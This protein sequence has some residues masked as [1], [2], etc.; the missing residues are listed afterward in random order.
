[1]PCEVREIFLER[2]DRREA[3]GAFSS[4]AAFMTGMF[5]DGGFRYCPAI[6]N[7]ILDRDFGARL[8]GR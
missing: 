4:L 8:A 6:K 5:V 1:M 7:H 3:I 2:I